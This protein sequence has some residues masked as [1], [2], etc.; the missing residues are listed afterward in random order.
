MTEQRY[1]AGGQE[2]LYPHA[3]DP[4]PPVDTKVLLL[5]RGGICTTGYWGK[6]WCIGWLPLPKRNQQ[7]EDVK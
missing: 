5:S 4:L 2:F 7:K 1:F 6:H 3:G